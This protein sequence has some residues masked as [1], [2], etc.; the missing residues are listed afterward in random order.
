VSRVDNLNKVLRGLQSGSPD[1]EASA[2]ISE[3]GLMIASA[4]PQHVEE[5][6]VAGMTAT[7]LGLG[8]RAASELERGGLQEVLIRGQDGYA[9]MMDAGS[10]TLLLSMATREAKLGLLFLDM[11]RAVEDIRRVL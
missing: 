1:V 6:R 5:A 8:T 11:R 4:L 3:D 2:L 9:C 10:G 7:L